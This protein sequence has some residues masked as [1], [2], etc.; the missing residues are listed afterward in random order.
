[1]NIYMTSH[2]N[3]LNLIPQIRTQLNILVKHHPMHNII[4]RGDFNRDIVLQRHIHEGTPQAPTHEDKEWAQHMQTLTLHP[5]QNTET[6]SRQ[7]GHNYSSTN[8]IDGFYTNMSNHTHTS[9]AQLYSTK[10]GTRTT[11]PSA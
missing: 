1:M 3:D 7:G 9:H 10:I 2:P 4:Q 8:L 11:I 6:L 5:T